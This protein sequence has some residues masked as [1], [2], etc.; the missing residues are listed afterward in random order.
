MPAGEKSRRV[1]EKWGFGRRLWRRNRHDRVLLNGSV[2]LA[3][4]E[5]LLRA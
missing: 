1:H 2:P 4:L 3:V 5:G